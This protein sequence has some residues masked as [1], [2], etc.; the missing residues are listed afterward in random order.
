[1]RRRE[2]GSGGEALVAAVDDGLRLEGAREVERALDLGARARRQQDRR[3]GADHVGER[4]Q[5]AVVLGTAH[6]DRIVGVAV[7]RGGEVPGVDEELAQIGLDAHERAREPA[8]R[9]AAP[10]RVET[11]RDAIGHHVRAASPVVGVPG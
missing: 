11:Q 9:R 4:Q 7:G 8:P 6:A 10:C 5:R 2:L 3:A 1:V